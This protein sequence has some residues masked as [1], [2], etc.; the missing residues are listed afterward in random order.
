MARGV[1]DDPRKFVQECYW[2]S[3]I[4]EDALAGWIIR[5]I[6]DTEPDLLQAQIKDQVSPAALS[7]WGVIALTAV[8][9]ERYDKAL[10]IVLTRRRGRVRESSLSVVGTRGRKG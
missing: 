7:E 6:R 5:T 1:H 3:I 8:G 9:Q 10:D 4:E 2:L